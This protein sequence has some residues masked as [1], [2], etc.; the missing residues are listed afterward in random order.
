MTRERERERTVTN[1]TRSSSRER[2]RELD[3]EIAFLAFQLP[4]Y[5]GCVAWTLAYDTL[6]AHQDKRDDAALGLRYSPA[7][8][9]AHATYSR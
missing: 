6:Y 4:L 1:F 5:A 8:S 2:E 3:T 7:P 9:H